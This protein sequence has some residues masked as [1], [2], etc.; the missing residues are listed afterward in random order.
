MLEGYCKKYFYNFQKIR[1]QVT[2]T[3]FL[4]DL[5]KFKTTQVHISLDGHLI[6]RHNIMCMTYDTNT[7]FVTTLKLVN[8]NPKRNQCL[9]FFEQ[10][11]L[12][13]MFPVKRRLGLRDESD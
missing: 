10:I 13:V 4:V 5:N 7:K 9:L 12:I 6:F 3:T 1:D 11:I 8:C 2:K